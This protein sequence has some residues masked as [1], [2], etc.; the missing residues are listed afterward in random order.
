MILFNLVCGH[1]HQFEAWFRDGAAYDAQ[2]AGGE[3][4]CPLCGDSH[5]RKAPMAPSLVKG[6]RGEKEKAATT[7]TPA[8]PAPSVPAT[9]SADSPMARVGR[10][11]SELRRQIESQCDYVGKQFPEEARRIHHGEAQERPIYGE[12]SEEDAKALHEEG[13]DII[14]LPWLRRHDS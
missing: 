12:A 2:A 5:V 3:I 7:Q 10:A 1:D 6:G 14:S 9:T 11:L 4:T 8:A 13:V